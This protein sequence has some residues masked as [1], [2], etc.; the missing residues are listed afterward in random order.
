MDHVTCRCHGQAALCYLFVVLEAM[1]AGFEVENEN[2]NEDGEVKR[3]EEKICTSMDEG[4]CLVLSL[5]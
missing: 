4:Y 3:R 5:I 1:H 2:V